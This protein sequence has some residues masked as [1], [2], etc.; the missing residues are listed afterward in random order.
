MKKRIYLDNAATTAMNP[1]VLAAMVPYYSDIYGN[2]SSLHSYGT[3][4]K[5]ALDSAR[6]VLANCLGALPEEMIFTS[7][8]TESNNLALKVSDPGGS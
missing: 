1:A 7:S 5:E 3:R 6:S 4:A 8:G 2:A